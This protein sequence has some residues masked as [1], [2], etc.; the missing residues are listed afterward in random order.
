M[1]RKPFV[2]KYFPLTC[3]TS[4][5]P[6]MTRCHLLA[7]WMKCDVKINACLLLNMIAFSF[8]PQFCSSTVC[9]LGSL[10]LSR[11]FLGP[12]KISCPTYRSAAVTL[13][14]DC[15]QI[16][17]VYFS[18]KCVWSLSAVYISLSAIAGG[19]NQHLHICL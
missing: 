7:L 8:P 1:L 12:K 6:K 19:I 9:S 18:F 10:Q 14:H 16:V 13:G 2:L 4:D 3:T 17:A 11:G 15:M 5:H